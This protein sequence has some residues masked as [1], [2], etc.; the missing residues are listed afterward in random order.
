[1]GP[2][3]MEVVVTE[4]VV[5]EEEHLVV[6]VVYLEEEHEEVKEEVANSALVLGT[7]LSCT[8]GTGADPALVLVLK[9]CQD[10]PILTAA[11]CLA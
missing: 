2:R 6:A 4:V 8:R 5:T 3:C 1:M 9:I 10:A 7:D 11:S